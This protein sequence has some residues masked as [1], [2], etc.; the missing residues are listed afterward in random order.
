MYLF[1]FNWGQVIVPI[2]IALTT[3]LIVLQVFLSKRIKRYEMV[4][5]VFIFITSIVVTIITKE[6]APFMVIN[7]F[8][9]VLFITH[10]IIIRNNLNK[11]D[12]QKEIDIMKVKDLE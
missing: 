9:I 4:P 8:S 10:I 6:F 1:I 5:I 11:K 7:G 3:I 2:V 12:Q